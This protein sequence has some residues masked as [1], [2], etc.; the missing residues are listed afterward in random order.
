[1]SAD[2]S[3]GSPI[4][5]PADTSLTDNDVR[6]ALAF[7]PNHDQAVE[8][9]DLAVANTENPDVLALAEQIRVS[10]EPEIDLMRT[11]VAEQDAATVEASA[12]A[13]PGML[14]AEQMDEL[15]NA[16]GEDFDRLFVRYMVIKH[17]GAIETVVIVQG[18]SSVTVRGLS[19]VISQTLGEEIDQ[20]QAI[21]AG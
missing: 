5:P 1:M 9:V 3:E 7:L 6:F 8:I 21:S 12:A 13:A 4:A 15:R 14:T 11:W 20:L 19:Q 10:R 17:E 16:K 18:S 2:S